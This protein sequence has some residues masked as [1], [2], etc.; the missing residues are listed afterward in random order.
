MN[1][2]NP[3][4]SK[5]SDA[6]FNKRYLTGSE[7]ARKRIRNL[8]IDQTIPFLVNFWVEWQMFSSSGKSMSTVIFGE[9]WRWVF[10][11]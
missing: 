7:N 2:K 1:F 5:L 6:I 4:K 8:L 9:T 3:W 10:L 11:K